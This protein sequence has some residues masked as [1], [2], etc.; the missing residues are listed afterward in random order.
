MRNILVSALLAGAAL[1]VAVPAQ[2]AEFIQINNAGLTNKIK[3]YS[4]NDPVN[5]HPSTGT[6][7]YGKTETGDELVKFTGNTVLNITDG[8]GYAQISDNDTT[9]NVGWNSLTVAFD[10]YAYG[11]TGLE[12]SLQF[13]NTGSLN[14][15]AF[16]LDGSPSETFTYSPINGNTGFFLSADVGEVFSHVV[17]TSGDNPFFQF[18]QAEIGIA[19]A[20]PPAVPEP[21]T[22][23]MMI[24]GLG[25]AGAAL[26]RRATKVQFA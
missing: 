3:A 2:A 21:A 8:S 9:D 7:V 5:P 6:S 20:P 4:D 13:K 15:E 14:V 1:A 24:G 19:A 22:W 16:F 10:S 12:F 18:K 23:A 17:L 26:R 25:L 11:F